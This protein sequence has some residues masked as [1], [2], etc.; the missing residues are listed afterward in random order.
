MDKK[1][2]WNLG[3]SKS[4]LFQ[5]ISAS[6]DELSAEFLDPNGKRMRVCA[7]IQVINSEFV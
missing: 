3:F 7:N 5:I 2:V 1:L 6:V 4:N